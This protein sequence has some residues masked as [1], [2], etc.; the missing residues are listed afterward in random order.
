MTEWRYEL[1]PLTPLHIAAGDTIEPFEYV[2]HEGRLYKFDPEAFLLAL[3][4]DEQTEF[5]NLAGTNLLKARQFMSAHSHLIKQLAEY[6]L[7][8]SATAAAYYEQRLQNPQSD[9]SIG[10]F[11]RTN[12]RAYIPGS[13]LKGALR[14]A[15]LY[16]RARKPISGWRA[17]MLEA[18]TFHYTRERRDGSTYPS[19]TDDPFKYFKISDSNICDDLTQLVAVNV[20]TKSAEGWAEGRIPL[21]REVTWG[22]LTNHAQARKA[23]TTF[24]VIVTHTVASAAHKNEQAKWFDGQQ[25]VAACRAFYGEHLKREVQFHQDDE[26]SSM[27]YQALQEWEKELPEEA[28][29][30]R[31]GWGSGF[32]AVTVRYAREGAKD[33]AIPRPSRKRGDKRKRLGDAQ[34]DLTLYTPASR[35]LTEN[36][37]PLGWAE[38]RIVPLDQ[39]S[40]IESL[41]KRLAQVKEIVI[42]ETSSS[43]IAPVEE[44]QPA[45]TGDVEDKLAQWKKKLAKDAPKEHPAPAKKDAGAQ[46]RR[47]QEEIMRRMRKGS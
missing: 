28:C 10:V 27:F 8:V 46:A 13:S 32:D 26:S 42:S 6:S 17:E 31:F 9:L 14:T 24:S 4:P 43:E 2:I 22:V 34:E 47:Q 11:I 35:R 18:E 19:V 5:V 7:P 25:I 30:V 15:L 16:Q 33:V 44:S 45:D 29:L 37:E 39:S 23:T 41:E 36:G 21:L 1:T 12:R 20:H 3:A 40:G 38:L